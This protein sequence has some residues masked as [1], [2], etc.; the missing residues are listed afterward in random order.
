M[1]RSDREI[2][3]YKKYKDSKRYE[4]GV[5]VDKRYSKIDRVDNLKAGLN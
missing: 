5:R 2:H 3:T 4:N 1:K